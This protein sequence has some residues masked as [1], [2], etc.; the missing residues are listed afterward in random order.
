MVTNAL[1]LGESSKASK[2]YIWN[3]IDTSNS[4][5]AILLYLFYSKTKKNFNAVKYCHINVVENRDII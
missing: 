3:Q 4:S 1:L 5:N 2:P